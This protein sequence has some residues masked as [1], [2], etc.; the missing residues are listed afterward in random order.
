MSNVAMDSTAET[1]SDVVVLDEEVWESLASQ[2]DSQTMK[3][4]MDIFFVDT[5]DR[6]KKVVQAISVKDYQTIGFEAHSIKSTARTLGAFRL[7][8]VCRN[9]E[10]ASDNGN[11]TAVMR[12]SQTLQQ[13]FEETRT[14]FNRRE[15]DKA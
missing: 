3:E 10:D 1:D 5:Q 6:V 13:A 14:A 12:F 8:N 11:L 7:A 4:I 2:T 15:L 9:I